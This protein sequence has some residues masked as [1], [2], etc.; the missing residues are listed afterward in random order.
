MSY[1][2]ERNATSADFQLTS[3]W[4]VQ[5]GAVLIPSGAFLSLSDWTWNSVPLP[6]APPKEAMAL[7]QAGFNKLAQFYPS[8]Q[9]QS[10]S[11]DI[12]R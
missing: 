11:P 6:S 7:T 5:G 9:I 3:P 10:L 4:P 8:Y 12:V 1:S 2:N